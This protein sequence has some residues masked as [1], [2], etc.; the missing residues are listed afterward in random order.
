MRLED[1]GFEDKRG[2]AGRRM[3]PAVEVAKDPTRVGYTEKANSL[4]SWRDYKGGSRGC[5]EGDT[6]PFPKKEIY[7]CVAAA[8]LLRTLIS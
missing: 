8:F 6:S 1:D 3:S 7:S 4:L 5:S 2:V